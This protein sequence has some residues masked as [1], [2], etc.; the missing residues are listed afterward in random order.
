M[1]KTL[2]VDDRLENGREL[3]DH[4]Q[5]AG[6]DVTAACWAKLVEPDQWKLYVVSKYVD[7][8]GLGAAYR[9]VH[10]ILVRL[11]RPRFSLSDF[12]LFGTKTALA[13]DILEFVAR[14]PAST[15]SRMGKPTLGTVEIEEA[16]VYPSVSGLLPWM[17]KF[18]RRFPTVESLSIRVAVGTLEFSTFGPCVNHINADEFLGKA[19]GT[20]LFLGPECNGSR[21]LGTLVFAYRPEGWNSLL[22]PETGKWEAVRFADTGHPLYQSA[23]FAP[24]LALKA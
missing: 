12:Q 4:L 19:P 6:F 3:L 5:R 2:L 13:A 21:S 8:E 7:E 24:L 18:E 20:V 9:A 15:P 14:N 17:E 16:W 23:D 11:S 1:D 10:P 22:N